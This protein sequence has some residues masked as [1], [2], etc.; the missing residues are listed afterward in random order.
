M[1]LDHTCSRSFVSLHRS[2][3]FAHF[4]EAC[5]D[6]VVIESNTDSLS[7]EPWGWGL[8]GKRHKGTIWADEIILY[9]DSIF[10]SCGLHTCI[11]LSKFIKHKMM[12][13]T[14]CKF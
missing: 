10:V 4:P 1:S 6:S 9:L 2:T 3:V 13:F 5:L 11:H 8:I 7:L 12:H 14:V